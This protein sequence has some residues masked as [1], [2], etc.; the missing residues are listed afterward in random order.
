MTE[1]FATFFSLDNFVITTIIP[2]LF[3]LTVV[4]FVHEMGHYLVGRWCGIGVREFSIGFGP[5]LIGFND[6]KG[7]RWK[8]SAIPLGGYVKFLGDM[9][10]TSDPASQD[11]EILTPEERKAA[12]HV[13]PIWKRAATVVAG[14]FFNFL[15][16]IA[17]FAVMFS[18]YGRWVSEPTVAEVRPDSPAA[19]AG[20]QPG[21]RFVSI[22]G[23]QVKTFGDVQRLVSGRAGDSIAFVMARG[24]DEVNLTATP[25][26]VEQT[27][28]LGN[29]IRVGV[30]GVVNNQELGQP[31]HLT[32][33]PVQALGEAMTE[34]WHVITRT[35]QFLQRFVVGRE[36]RCQLGGPVR[37]A[38]MSGQAAA[39]GFSWLVQLVALLSVGIG[40]LNLLPIPPLDGG[41]LAF[42]GVEAVMRRPVSERV[43][44]AVYRVG[45]FLVL[46]F[47]LFVFWND[48]FGC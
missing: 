9:A 18:L 38:E 30:I 26:I 20:F 32:F 46:G 27:D 36:D 17:V 13:Q 43:M 39:M 3:V 33:T 5:E 29:T 10:V 19:V 31:R 44:E 48:L 11:T 23:T 8:L 47:M 40:I 16:T 28:A 37:I 25:E 14:P 6:R 42:Y 12:F 22:N 45:L 7:T 24:E 1:F 15:L 41:H 34:T 4:V 2:F 21:D 35:G